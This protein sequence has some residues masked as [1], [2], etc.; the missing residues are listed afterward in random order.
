[1]DGPASEP[2][3]RAIVAR[4]AVAAAGLLLS[5]ASAAWMDLANWPTYA[6]FLA[7]AFAFSFLWLDSEAPASVPHMATA[8]AFL[9]IAGPSILFL[10]LVARAAAYPLLFAAARRGLIALP[11]ALRPLVQADPAAARQARLDLASML[12]VATI[13]SVVRLAVVWAATANSIESLIAIIAMGEPAAYAVM[14]ALSWL[15]PLPTGVY[16][17][18]APQRLPAED[19][20]IDVIVSALA[21]VPF[22]ALMIVYGWIEHGL[23]G[24]AAWSLTTLP[25]HWLMQ[26]LAKRRHLLDAHHLVLTQA[27]AS[28][29]RKQQELEDFTYTVAHDLKAPLSAITMTADLLLEAHGAA[30]PDAV[31]KNVAEIMRRAAE[32]EDMIVDLLRMVRVVTEPEEVETVDLGIITAQAV[33]MLGP[34]IA[35][36]RVCVQVSGA[37]PSISGQATK[38]RH[39]VANLIGNAIRFV[40]PERGVV[41]VQASWDGPSLKLT[42][43]DNG[44]GIPKEYHDVIFEPFRRVP[45]Q[46]D[47][48]PGTGMGL[49]IVKRIV[50]AHGGRVLVQSAP[51]Q[52]STIAV[53]LP[54]LALMPR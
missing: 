44:V 16:L 50:E 28:L 8:T 2:H 40:P 27:T 41:R 48:H 17:T 21:I 19:A 45:G 25:P 15:L 3:P 32:T 52:G 38:L 47:E 43:T 1:M 24:A 42:F 39:V 4:R 10:E 5:L 12:G 49:A 9:Y 22:L 46:E 30:L 37:L 36:R 7:L 23:L 35:A 33:D 6:V 20:R 11:R 26:L 54:R 31:R 14:G 29:A 51:G 18:V 53:Q 13:G 34:Q